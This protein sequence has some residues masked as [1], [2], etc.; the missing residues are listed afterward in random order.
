ME[1][2]KLNKIIAVAG[3]GYVGLSNA[4]LL[5]A[6]HTV[7]AL[8]VD[9]GRVAMLNDRKCPII[10]DD[11]ARHL[12]TQTLVVS[13]GIWWIGFR[14]NLSGSDVQILQMYS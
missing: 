11:I 13:P 9:A 14:M 3:I 1:A 10:D 4:F 12:A 5:A 7:R 8:D 6:R 2:L